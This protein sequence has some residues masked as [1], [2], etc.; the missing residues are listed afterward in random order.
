MDSGVKPAYNLRSSC[1]RES[2]AGMPSENPS[3][4]ADGSRTYDESG[5]VVQAPPGRWR[6]VNCYV[7]ASWHVRDR[8]H[9][10]GNSQRL[11][12]STAFFAM[13]GFCIAR[14]IRASRGPPGTLQ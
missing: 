9:E 5:P 3:L 13:E 12:P 7:G 1:K 11:R 4:S 6:Y 10:S 14:L 8:S 2:A